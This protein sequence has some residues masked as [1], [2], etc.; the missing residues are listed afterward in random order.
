[1]VCLGYLITLSRVCINTFLH[2]GQSILE[3]KLIKQ[4]KTHS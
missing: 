3:D 4:Y 1:M 2:Y